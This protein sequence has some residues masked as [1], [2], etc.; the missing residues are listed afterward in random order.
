MFS[1]PEISFV[2]CSDPF[3]QA[4]NAEYRGKNKPTDVL[5]FAQDDPQMLGD[6][7]VSVPAAV[8]QAEAAGWPL[9]SEVA[10]LAVH[11]LLHLLGYD[12]ETER[13]AWDMQRRTEAALNEA[14]I[15]IPERGRH[16]F[17]VEESTE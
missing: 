8:R 9:E 13:G 6:I 12:D 4:L 3:I 1:D 17:F 10:M 7:I 16:P 14:R 2:F 15:V 11:G 5:S